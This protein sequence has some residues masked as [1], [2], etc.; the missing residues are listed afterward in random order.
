MGAIKQKLI[1]L[2]DEGIIRWSDDLS[3]YVFTKSEGTKPFDI[4]QYMRNR[5]LKPP[6]EKPPK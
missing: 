4:D 1:E 6:Y 2:E 3:A 5:N